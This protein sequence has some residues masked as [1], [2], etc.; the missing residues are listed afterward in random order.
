LQGLHEHGIVRRELNPATIVIRNSD[1]RAILTEFELAKLIDRG[2]TVSTGEWPVDPYRA[3]EA[4]ADDIDVRADIYS[5]ARIAIHALAGHLPEIGS[6]QSTL[7][8][9]DL[10]SA[11]RECLTMSAAV[12]RSDRPDSIDAVVPVIEG[13]R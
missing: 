6:E 9:I 3:G 7:D 13:W 8:E 1:G 4:D 5:W 12:F 2:P 10:P 11:V